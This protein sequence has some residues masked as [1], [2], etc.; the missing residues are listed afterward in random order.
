[1]AA[2]DFSL[3]DQLEACLVEVCRER[4]VPERRHDELRMLLLMPESRWPSC[5]GARCE[6][7]VSDQIALAR[8]AYAR[9]QA[10][11]A[12]IG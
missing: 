2:R 11:L 1:M 6:P 3:P 12:A 7:C 8:E 10:Y 5:C 9:Y 4:A